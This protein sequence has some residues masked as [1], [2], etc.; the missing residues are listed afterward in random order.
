MRVAEDRQHRLKYSVAVTNK[1]FEPIDLQ[2]LLSNGTAQL[3]HPDIGIGMNKNFRLEVPSQ[4]RDLMRMWS[5][6]LGGAVY[7]TCETCS[8]HM[9]EYVACPLC[10]IRAHSTCM[11]PLATIECLQMHGGI[12]K[13]C[14]AVPAWWHAKLCKLCTLA[15]NYVDVTS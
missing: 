10:E 1:M 3:V 11:E 6:A 2:L 9:S 8:G 12:P 4:I 13:P 7:D 5:V 15:C 14:N